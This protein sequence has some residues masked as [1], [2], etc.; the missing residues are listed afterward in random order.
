MCPWAITS[1]STSWKAGITR[2]DASTIGAAPVEAGQPLLHR[3][4]HHAEHDPGRRV[5]AA[6]VGLPLRLAE[7]L[8]VLALQQSRRRRPVLVARE[9]GRADRGEQ[10]PLE[11]ALLLF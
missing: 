6:F 1:P 4:R 9:R 3:L 5:L 11:R 8:G 2:A 10:R 7:L